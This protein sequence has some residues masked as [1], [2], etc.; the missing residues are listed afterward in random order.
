MLR[1]SKH[2]HPDQTTLA[3]A[4][5]LLRELRRNRAVKFDDLKRPSISGQLA[6]IICSPC[7]EPSLPLGPRRVSTD[8]RRIRVHGAV[9]KLR[10]LYSNQPNVFSAI[11]FNPGLS[12]VL[13]EIRVPENQMLDT[14]NLGKT[15]VGELID[16]VFLRGSQIHF[17]CSSILIGL[18]C[19]RSIWKLSSETENSSQ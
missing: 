9:M 14:H 18:L 3:A 1:P 8:C 11:A 12:T 17:S 19:S 2:S 13:A 10:R 15:T 4:T 5:V 6:R 7:R 16:F